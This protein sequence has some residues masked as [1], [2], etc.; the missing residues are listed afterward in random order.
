VNGAEE[1]SAVAAVRP[2]PAGGGE[3]ANGA[4]AA[5]AAAATLLGALLR[6]PAFDELRTR[7]ALGYLVHASTHWVWGGAAALTDAG[8]CAHPPAARPPHCRPIRA[9]RPGGGEAD[10]VAVA[11]SSDAHAH[12]VLVVQSK[13][14][15]AAGVDERVC[16][17][18]ARG[19]LAFVE[20]LTEAAVRDAA[21]ALA[22]AGEEP[23]RDGAAAFAE[24]W[25]EVSG[26]TWRFQRAEEEARALRAVTRADVLRAARA[27]ARGNAGLS[28]EVVGKRE[29]DAAAAAA[30]E[31]PEVYEPPRPT[32]AAAAELAQPRSKDE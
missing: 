4:R 6:E 16:D 18:L 9:L 26:H 21:G 19:A 3:G 22:A 32:G 12:L 13:A 10:T 27:A 30:G 8:A 15:G 17:F 7:Q 1:N 28:V 11:A 24:V 14:V 2:L 23:P 20:G 5:A 25:A 31:H 29:V